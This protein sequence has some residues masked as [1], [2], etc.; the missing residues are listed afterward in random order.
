MTSRELLE[1]CMANDEI[2]WEYL[3]N[4]IHNNLSYSFKNKDMELIDEAASKTIIYFIN[5][6]NNIMKSK[7]EF[8][9]PESFKSISFD[10]SKKIMFTLLKKDKKYKEFIGGNP[11]ELFDDSSKGYYENPNLLKNEEHKRFEEQYSAIQLVEIIMNILNSSFKTNMTYCRLLL[12]VYFQ[13]KYY[14]ESDNVYE[15]I[16]HIFPNKNINELTI[17]IS[18]CKKKFYE[19]LKKKKI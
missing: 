11:Y 13:I 12:R 15:E 2:G 4:Y 18:R 6:F 17:I 16:N 10:I 19:I 8:N 9:N 1:K 7:D 5:K 14:E 3:Y